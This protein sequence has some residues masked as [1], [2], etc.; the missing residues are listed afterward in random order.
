MPPDSGQGVSCTVEDGLALGIL[1]K[2]YLTQTSTGEPNMADAL[3]RTKIGYEAVRLPWV[4]MILDMA[5]RI[6]ECKKKQT[7]FQ[8]KVRDW[9]M[10]VLCEFT[11][12]VRFRGALNMHCSHPPICDCDY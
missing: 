6:G 10:W 8:E 5:K 9:I 7:W 2:H 11:I 3:K 1:L 12:L 4:G